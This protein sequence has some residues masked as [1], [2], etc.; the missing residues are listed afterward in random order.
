MLHS[1]CSIP[2]AL[3]HNLQESLQVLLH[4]TK[5]GGEEY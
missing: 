5:K 4:L 2:S 3:E 1:L